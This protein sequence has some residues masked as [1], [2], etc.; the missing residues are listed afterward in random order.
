ME[1]TKFKKEVPMNC[2]RCGD[3]M[4]LKKFFDYGG[5]YWGWKCARCG[6]MNDQI[7]VQNLP[8]KE[9]PQVPKNHTKRVNMVK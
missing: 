9:F 2:H 1:I 5:Y 3:A 7:V 4:V 6:E 8:T